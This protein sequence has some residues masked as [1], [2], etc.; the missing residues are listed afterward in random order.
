VVTPAIDFGILRKCSIHFVR[1][2]LLFSIYLH[3]R[4]Y[5]NNTQ[6]FIIFSLLET[7]DETAAIVFK[8]LVEMNDTL[9]F[10]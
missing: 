9:L 6:S 10:K 5:T 2:I 8:D 7:N 4:V 1:V 3:N